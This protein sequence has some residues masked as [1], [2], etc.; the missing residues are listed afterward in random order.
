MDAPVFDDEE[1]EGGN[2]QVTTSTIHEQKAKVEK[3]GDLQCFIGLGNNPR[4][5]K[6]A[7]LQS[8]FKEMQRGMQF[9]DKYRFKWTQTSSE[10]NYMKFREGEHIVNHISNAK[11]FTNKITTLDTLQSLKMSLDCGQIQSTLKVDDFFPRTYRLDVVA[12]LVNFLN[13]PNEGLWL[14]KKAQSNQGKGI[15]LVSDVGKYK[16]DLLTIPDDEVVV[17]DSTKILMEK[18]KSMGIE[19]EEETKGEV[20]VP[21]I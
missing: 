16:D 1:I 6:D 18:L 11:I 10:V 14:V 17:P 15:T 9:S 12:D 20:T 21:E 4:L 13:S 3:K 5:A 19:N 2:G 7:L 8:G